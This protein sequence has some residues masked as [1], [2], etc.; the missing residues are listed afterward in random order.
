MGK[1]ILVT[2]KNTNA[3]KA[4]AEKLPDN[5]RPLV[6]DITCLQGGDAST[7]RKSLEKLDE[8]LKNISIRDGVINRVRATTISLYPW[9]NG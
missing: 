3:L 8:T 5:L 7:L 1:T 6:L 2:S 4:F 9:E